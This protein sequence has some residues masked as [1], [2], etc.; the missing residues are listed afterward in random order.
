MTNSAM[1]K[2]T[3]QT[4]LNYFAVQS[5]NWS[6]ENSFLSQ[7]IAT[8][9][10]LQS[11]VKSKCQIFSGSSVLKNADLIYFSW[12]MCQY[13]CA[14]WIAQAKLFKRVVLDQQNDGVSLFYDFRWSNK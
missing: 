4:E 10:C 6:P 5:M 8:V 12:C 2:S 1:N 9:I 13:I 11:F 3:S 7:L 14:L